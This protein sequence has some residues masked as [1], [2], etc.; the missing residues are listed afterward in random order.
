MAKKDEAAPFAAYLGGTTRVFDGFTTKSAALA[1]VDGLQV[2]E[3]LGK[4]INSS[5][6]YLFENLSA[7]VDAAGDEVAEI[8][9]ALGAATLI[10]ELQ[11]ALD[12]A[13]GPPDLAAVGTVLP[14]VKK[15]IRFTVEISGVKLPFDLD[16]ILE[17]IDELATTMMDLISPKGA[18]AMHRSEIRFLEAQVQLDRLAAVRQ[19]PI[20]ANGG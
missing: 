16:K 8:L 17:F 14:L 20:D 18:E 15:I 4:T 1:P 6:G 19:V 12:T 9:E 10:E 13:T 3:V 11:K 2:V 7:T 5:L